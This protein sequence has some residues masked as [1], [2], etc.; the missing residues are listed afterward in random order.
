MSLSCIEGRIAG[1][2]HSTNANTQKMWLC[3]YAD[4]A[5]SA[6]EAHHPE[7]LILTVR[8]YLLPC[9]AARS[10]VKHALTS[11]I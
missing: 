4:F 11:D 3:F 5:L 7:L 1:T 2:V 8:S 9:I 6:L 10:Y